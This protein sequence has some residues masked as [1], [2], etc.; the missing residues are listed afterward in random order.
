MPPNVDVPAKPRSAKVASFFAHPAT[1]TV[2][3]GIVLALLTTLFQLFSANTQQALVFKQQLRDKKFA[4]LAAVAEEFHRDLGVLLRTKK[5]K[6]WLNDYKEG[7][8]FEGSLGRDEVST[9]YQKFYEQYQMENKTSALM[10]QVEALFS[11]P[12]VREQAE[13]LTVQFMTLDAVFWKDQNR[14]KVFDET[15]DKLQRLEKAMADE[16]NDI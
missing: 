9:L 13:Q 15:E 1:L 6:A 3:G 14:S 8:M 11:N 2:V 16:I 12:R 5:M 10:A 4:L 7:D